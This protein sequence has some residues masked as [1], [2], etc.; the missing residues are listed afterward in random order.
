MQWQPST[1]YNAFMAKLMEKCEDLFNPNLIV[2]GSEHMYMM[3]HVK[4][5]NIKTRGRSG[6]FQ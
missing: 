6:H 4:L 1:V 5:S 2:I 3:K